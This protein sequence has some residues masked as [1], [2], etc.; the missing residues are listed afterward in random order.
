MGRHSKR[1]SL[2]GRDRGRSG[3]DGS[4]GGEGGG[5]RAP[6]LEE[7][8]KDGDGGGRR[9]RDLVDVLRMPEPSWRRRRRASDREIRGVRRPPTA[10]LRQCLLRGA[11][12]RGGEELDVPKLF[13]GSKREREE[14]TDSS[15]D[16][17][18]QEAG[19]DLEPTAER[20]SHR[21]WPAEAMPTEAELEGF[22][23]AAESESRRRFAERYNFDVVND[24]PFAGRFEWIRLA[25]GDE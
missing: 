20:D 1:G 9:D 5:R 12:V 14:I 16:D 18:N 13:L 22:F 24:A 7:E 17:E 11:E 6:A 8:E 2:V 15:S 3:N 10:W 21:R 4:D 23:A 25:H 19:F